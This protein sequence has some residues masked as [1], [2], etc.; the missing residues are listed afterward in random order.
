MLLPPP[1]TEQQ[2]IS[3]IEEDTRREHRHSG[4]QSHPKGQTRGQSYQLQQH[5][6]TGKTQV[7]RLAQANRG[8]RRENEAPEESGSRNEE[9]KRPLGTSMSIAYTYAS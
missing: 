5:A 8:E 1:A 2:G 6:E 7:K 4:C 3:R 9:A